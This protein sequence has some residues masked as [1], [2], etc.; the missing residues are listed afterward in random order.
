MHF[1]NP[2]TELPPERDPADAETEMF[3][4]KLSRAAA[5]IKNDAK[6]RVC[7]DCQSIRDGWCAAQLNINGNKLAVLYPNAVAC[8]RFEAR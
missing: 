4:D 3:T 5:E 1:G 8:D 6:G 7:R 2:G